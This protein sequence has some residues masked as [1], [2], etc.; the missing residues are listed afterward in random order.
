MLFFQDRGNHINSAANQ[1]H[2]SILNSIGLKSPSP[3]SNSDVLAHVYKRPFSF[4]SNE[5]SYLLYLILIFILS[6][7]DHQTSHCLFHPYQDN[8]APKTPAVTADPSP[9]ITI[10]GLLY[11]SVCNFWKKNQI[12][13]ATLKLNWLHGN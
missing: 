11:D 3:P 2:P 10:D 5:S 4:N 12:L 9:W 8:Q 13:Q 6:I 1:Q 7:S